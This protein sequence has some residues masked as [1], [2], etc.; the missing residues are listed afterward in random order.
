MPLI[1]F[2]FFLNTETQEAALAGNIPPQQ[3]L[4]VLQQIVVAELVKQAKEEKGKK[5]EKE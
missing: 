2:T 5:E 1:I 3:A 4:Q